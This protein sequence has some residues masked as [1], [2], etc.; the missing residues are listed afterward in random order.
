MR[1]FAVLLM[2]QTHAYDAWLAPGARP[3]AFFQW[4]RLLGGYPA[5][6]FLFLAGL[7]L[8]LTAEAHYR[9][10]GGVGGVRLWIRRGLEVFGYAILFR[11]WMFTTGGF[12]QPF[13]L[14]RVDVLNCMGLT[15]VAVA[16][17]ALR[18][19][20]REQRA[21]A[22]LGLAAAAAALTPLA[23]DAP[24]PRWLPAPL[25]AYVSGRAPGSFFPL[26]PWSAYTALGAAVGMA[27]A[28][29]REREREAWVIP[30]LAAAG[31]VAIPV[32]LA[33]DRLPTLYPR[34]DFW[35]TSPNYTLIKC[36]IVLLFLGCAWVWSRAP[37]AGWPSALRQMGQTS[38]LIYWVHIEMVYGAILLPGLRR[39]LSVP[40]A[41]LGL[42]VLSL[43]M[44][45]LSLLRTRWR[46]R[47]MPLIDPPP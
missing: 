10:G 46:P 6:L 28:W 39:S 30:G 11:L 2:M 7:S 36:G 19:P 20:R 38:L 1:G 43:T 33:L 14:L 27:L 5:P 29:A 15:M 8:A 26:F 47:V 45:L 25:L 3:T 42:L 12:S 4:S 31:A 35:W 22:C 17:L 21:L 16:T 32:G 13:D 37:W 44:L 18:W 41:S 23:W 40:Q 34:Y 9:K 24:W